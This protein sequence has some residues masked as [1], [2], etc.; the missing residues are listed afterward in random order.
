MTKNWI[1]TW[2]TVSALLILLFSQ[3]NRN[4]QYIP[5][6]RINK[7]IPDIKLI[8]LT[9]NN[10]INIA[11][12]APNSN[13]IVHFWATWCMTCQ[14]EHSQL[15]KLVKLSNTPW[16]GVVYKDNIQQVKNWLNRVG[17]PYTYTLFDTNGDLA[18]EM[19]VYGTP[20]TFLI[21]KNGIILFRYEGSINENIWQDKFLPL[22]QGYN[23]D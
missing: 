23:N 7:K 12:L 8:Q 14:A 21:N 13:K 5:N 3:I 2:T 11:S 22:I 18:I 6:A 4:P 10:K 19:G 15:E 16:V 17:N 1:I 20:E 9:T